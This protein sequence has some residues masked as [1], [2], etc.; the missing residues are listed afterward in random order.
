MLQLHVGIQVAS[1]FKHRFKGAQIFTG[2]F[3]EMGQGGQQSG[4]AREEA[5]S[6]DSEGII[7]GEDGCGRE[8]PENKEPSKEFV[9]LFKFDV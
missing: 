4:P 6:D 1:S 7:E 8:P 9:S 2:N 3:P 5:V